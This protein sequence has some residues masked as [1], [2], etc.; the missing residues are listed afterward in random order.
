MHPDSSEGLGRMRAKKSL[1]QN[2][3]VDANIQRKIVDALPCSSTDS[4]L[5]IGPGHGA[6]TRHL[7]GR[8]GRLVLVELD[9]GNVEVQPNGTDRDRRVADPN[10][11]SRF[12]ARGSCVDEPHLVEPVGGGVGQRLVVVAWFSLTGIQEFVFGIGHSNRPAVPV[13]DDVGVDV[14]FAGFIELGFWLG[15]N[16]D[17]GDCVLEASGD[18]PLEQGVHIQ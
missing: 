10:R 12:F 6:L 4:V 16:G 14:D 8:V 15:F 18:V 11:S 7:V 2:F 5:E 13:E 9:D 17:V 1:G 3:L